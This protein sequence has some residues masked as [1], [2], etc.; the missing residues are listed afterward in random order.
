MVVFFRDAE[1]A[2]G[3]AR[4]A[5]EGQPDTDDTGRLPELHRDGQSLGRLAPLFSFSRRLS[6]EG[7]CISAPAV[8][9]IAP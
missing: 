3:D 5:P 9:I 7:L 4:R 6:F 2:E 1:W 8:E